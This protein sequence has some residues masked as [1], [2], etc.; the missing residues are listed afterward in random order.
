MS[1]AIVGRFRL[2]G[3]ICEA[4]DSKKF[5]TLVSLAPCFSKVTTSLLKGG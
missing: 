4:G 1:A 2:L 3:L 5:L